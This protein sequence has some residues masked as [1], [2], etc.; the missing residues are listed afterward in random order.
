LVFDNRVQ[1]I[2]VLLDT[3]GQLD[4]LFAVLIDSL[5]F[6]KVAEDELLDDGFDLIDDFLDVLVI[7]FI[8]IEHIRGVDFVVVGEVQVGGDKFD[9]VAD[10]VDLAGE[11]LLV[12]HVAD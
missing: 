11:L 9:L 8:A 10:G 6:I 7:D 12:V 2:N 3:A 4:N 5:G 1:N